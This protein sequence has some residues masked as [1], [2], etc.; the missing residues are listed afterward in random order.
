MLTNLAWAVCL[1]VGLQNAVVC[2][3]L[4]LYVYVNV[5]IHFCACVAYTQGACACNILRSGCVSLCL[6]VSASLCALV[7]P[8]GSYCFQ[9]T[10]CVLATSALSG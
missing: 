1:C 8:G 2:V 7:G 9:G 10:L 4:Y 6:F 3:Y 5:Y